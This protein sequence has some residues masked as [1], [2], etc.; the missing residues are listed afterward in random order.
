MNFSVKI[1]LE[2]RFVAGIT[3]DDD[4][5]LINV[6]RLLEPE[7]LDRSSEAVDRAPILSWV[8]LIRLDRF[9]R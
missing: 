4:A 6:N 7:L 1:L 2:S 8:L 5:V 9:N 3:S